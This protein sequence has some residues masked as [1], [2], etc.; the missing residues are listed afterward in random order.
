VPWSIL[1]RYVLRELRRVFVLSLAAITGI[2]VMAGIVAEAAQQ[3][4]GPGQILAAIPLLIPGLLPFTV[5]ATTLFAVSVVYGRLAHDN[6]ITAIKAAGIP[7]TRVVRPALVAGVVLSVGLLLLYAR[8]IP[9]THHLLRTAALRDI[10]ELIYT[11]L[12]KD[13]C[14]NKPEVNYSIYVKEVQGRRLITAT[15][16]KRDNQGRDEVIAHAREAEIKVDL[17]QEVVNIFM[18]H[19]E[20]QKGMGEH[21]AF[22][23]KYTIPV[24]LPPIGLNRKIR[25]RELSLEQIR[26]RQQE[27]RQ[28]QEDVQA[29]KSLEPRKGPDGKPRDGLLPFL[30]KDMQMKMLQKEFWEL[31]TEYHTR[32]AL[33]MSCLFFVL[34][35]VPVGV[36]VHKRDYLSAFVTC[37]LPIVLV[38]YPL[39][40]FG[41]NL[42]KEG[43]L[44]PAYAMWVGNAVLGLAGLFLFWRL[45]RR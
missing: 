37:F 19:A 3:G 6:E 22:F 35:G 41:I 32:P 34:V 5:P 31:E 39:M 24:P 40:M 7:V 12:R 33:A 26:D 28:A 30:N 20:I 18:L 9:Y 29:G 11:I 43:K 38:Y 4:F 25:A 21:S 44:N 36:W 15:F 42:G 23:E 10:E 14:F 16:K 27:I 13:L 45:V 2:L 1:H 8:F 17:D